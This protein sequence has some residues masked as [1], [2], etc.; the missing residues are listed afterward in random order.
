MLRFLLFLLFTTFCSQICF[1]QSKVFISAEAG[2]SDDHFK[3]N[4]PGNAFLVPEAG[5]GYF[6]LTAGR[7]FSKHLYVESG[8][9]TRQYSE[10]IR[11]AGSEGGS[12]GSGRRFAQVPIRIGGRWEFINSRIAVRPYGG[13][14]IN[15]T[16]KYNRGGSRMDSTDEN[17]N[18]TTIYSYEFRYPTDVFALAQAGMTL[19]C[20]IAKKT[21]LGIS[22]SYNWGGEKMM[23]QDIVYTSNGTQRKATLSGWGN[24]N[25]ITASLSFRLGK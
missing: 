13:L 24:F 7:M 21:Y 8:I 23:I 16:S 22:S 10:Q 11:R 4:D 15:V 18:V 20:R 25:S 1:S 19:E 9:Y 3:M 5:S 12:G 17:G 2:W 14:V 6:G